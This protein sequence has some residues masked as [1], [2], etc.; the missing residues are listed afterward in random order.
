[1]GLKSAFSPCLASLSR[2]GA[3]RAE[4]GALVGGELAQPVGEPGVAAGAVG[5]ERG[6]GPR[7]ERHD[8]DLAAVGLVGAADDVAAAPR[9]S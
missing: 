3:A 8:D 4:D 6:R 1:M 2:I 7:S 9:G 5:E